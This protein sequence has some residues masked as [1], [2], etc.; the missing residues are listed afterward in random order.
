MTPGTGWG[1]PLKGDRGVWR[2]TAYP[3]LHA[4]DI[5]DATFE[6]H[7]DPTDPPAKLTDLH[8]AV[9]LDANA[10]TVLSLSTQQLGLDTQT[11]NTVFAGPATGAAAVPT[12]R[13]LTEDDLPA[14]DHGTGG[15]A[16]GYAASIG[17]GTNTTYNV[18]HS[19]NTTDVLVQ[20]W[21]TGV[22][23]RELVSP[24]LYVV[25]VDTVRVTFSSAPT[26]NQYRIVIIG[27]ETA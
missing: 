7:N 6:Y 23:P 24:D 11:A 21:D 19:L 22:T 14:H 16:A 15:G 10:D 17:D 2:V 18:T 20:V 4:D 26:S 1:V 12:F 5:S 9:T 8:D 25:D 3:T 27:V 13:A